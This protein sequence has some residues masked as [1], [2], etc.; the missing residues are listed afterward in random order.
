M[1]IFHV[2]RKLFS[3]ATL[4]LNPE[5]TSLN[6]IEKLTNLI[7]M[8]LDWIGYL[9]SIIYLNGRRVLVLGIELIHYNITYL[10]AF[11]VNTIKDTNQYFMAN[12]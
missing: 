2:I 11:P 8:Q 5:P 6:L 7:I 9:I 1:V 4:L 12:Y 10:P 3:S